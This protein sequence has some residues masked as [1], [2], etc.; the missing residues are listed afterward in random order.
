[1][2][3]LEGFLPGTVTGSNRI[4]EML[5]TQNPSLST[6]RWRVWSARQAGT[7]VSVIIFVEDEALAALK[8]INFATYF[9]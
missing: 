7:N 5:E 2:S 4:L 1:M 8:K 3:R 6:R 9:G